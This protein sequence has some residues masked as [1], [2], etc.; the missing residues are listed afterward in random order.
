M[1]RR[2]AKMMFALAV[3]GSALVCGCNYRAGFLI[4][5]DVKSVHVEVVANE[6]F[7]HEAVKTDNV[8]T[9]SPLPAP[10]P[11]YPMEVDLTERIK[12]EIV[13]RTRLKL[14]NREKADSVLRASISGVKPSVLMRD[15]ADDV[16]AQRITIAVNFTWTDRRNGRVLAQRTGI[17]RPTDYL[18]ARKESFTT[19]A[20]KS[21]GY[22]AEQIVEGM[23]EGF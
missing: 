21:F 1:T 3:L 4:P 11:A 9:A 12:N 15:A 7:W 13:R 5:A 16:L 19:A 10:R 2:C 6:T 20:R 18:A 8:P 23:Q 14:T 22:V 17:A